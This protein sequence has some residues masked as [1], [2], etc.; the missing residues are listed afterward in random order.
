MSRKV[1]DRLQDHL[2]YPPRTMRLDRA[3]AY[4]DLS[5]STFLRLVDDGKLP[6]GKKVRGVVFWDR[7]AL[8]A[9]VDN[10]EGDPVNTFDNAF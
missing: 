5:R 9:F 6:K 10:F 1:A 2:A 3:A 7:L 8:D 4:L